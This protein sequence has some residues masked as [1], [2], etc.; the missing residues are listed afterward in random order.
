MPEHR[1]REIIGAR[2]DTDAKFAYA[3]LPEEEDVDFYVERMN[4]G[5][6]VPLAA[7]DAENEILYVNGDEDW[8]FA[9]DAVPEVE[10]PSSDYLGWRWEEDPEMATEFDSA[11]QY[12]EASDLEVEIL[13]S[14]RISALVDVYM[15][16]DLHDAVD[17][18]S[19]TLTEPDNS[20]YPV[21]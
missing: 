12:A 17:A 11:E 4:T 15:Q 7:A 21:R 20:D 10:R 6:E 14:E 1:G 18:Y 8:G 5:P 13:D 3:A 19:I 9:R 2:F 16:R